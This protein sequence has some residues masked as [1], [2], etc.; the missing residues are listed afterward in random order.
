MET[1]GMETHGEAMSQVR[2]KIG[3]G[4]RPGTVAG[5]PTT[6]PGRWRTIGEAKRTGQVNEA[7]RGWGQNTT[8]ATLARSRGDQPHLDAVEERRRRSPPQ[9]R[10]V[11]RSSSSPRR[12]PRFP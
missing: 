7:R 2:M 4:K 3:G 11:R 5:R 12:E 8:F 6:W 10:S 9:L 1:R